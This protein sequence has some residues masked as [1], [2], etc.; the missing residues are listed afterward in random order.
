[1]DASPLTELSLEELRSLSLSRSWISADA[2][3]ELSRRAWGLPVE[4]PPPSA[5]PEAA[6]AAAT[7]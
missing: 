6:P 7:A 5:K 3:R 1:M 2:A 4:A